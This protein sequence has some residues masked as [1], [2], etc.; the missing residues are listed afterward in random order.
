[1]NSFLLEKYLDHLQ[2]SSVLKTHK[3]VYLENGKAS[4]P[5]FLILSLS[6][7]KNIL[8][9]LPDEESTIAAF[10]ELY[11]LA[12]KQTSHFPP[13][14]LPNGEPY[15]SYEFN[16]QQRTT[17]LHQITSSSN[18]N[19]IVT[20]FSALTEPVIPKEHF[21]KHLFTIHQNENISYNFL[22][23]LLNDYQFIQSEFVYFPGQYAVRGHIIDIY[24]YTSE[25]PFRIELRNNTIVR[26]SE[27][28]PSTQMS[29]QNIEQA[30]IAPKT[31]TIYT[32]TSCLT[33]YFSN[34]DLFIL[35][36]PA[37]FKE[38]ETCQIPKQTILSEIFQKSHIEY[39]LTEHHT[40]PKI[41][42]QINPQPLFGK[43]YEDLAK[44]L[45][46][47]YSNGFTNVFVSTNRHSYQRLLQ[48]TEDILHKEKIETTKPLMEW[49]NADINEGFIDVKNKFTFYTEHQIFEKYHPIRKKDKNSETRASLTLK[50]LIQLNPGD[51]VVHIDHGIGRFAGL[52]TLEVNGKK[53]E[54]IKLL[55]KNNDTLF[56]NIH[57][58]YRLSKYS[59]KDGHEPKI[60][61][62]GSQRWQ[63][64][65][66]KIKTSVKTLAYDL[67]KLYAERK[68]SEGFAFSKDTYLQ[69]ELEAS[70]PFED[71]PD[72]A[73]VTREVKRDM[74]KPY[75][76]DRLICGD[77]GFG[78]TEIAIRAAF[79]AVCDG[80][81]VV[82]L[83]PTTIL[84]IQHF[85]TFSER[86]KNFPVTID[87]INRF[88]TIKEQKNILQKLQ[89]GKIDI[90][91]GTHKLLSKNVRFNDLGLLIID[92]EHK[93][94]VADKDKIKLLKKNIDT[95][96]LTAT[97]IPRTLQFSLIGA[98]DLSVIQTPPPNRYPVKT[99]LHNFSDDIIQAAIL[100]EIERG[101]QVFFIHNKVQDIF[102]MAQHIQQLVPKIRLSVAHGQMKNYELEDAVI[103][104]IRGDAQVLISTNIIESG[105]DISNANT[106]IIHNAQNFG[107]S[108]LHQ[109]RGRVGRSNRQAYCYLLV[110]SMNLLTNDAKKRLQAIL[111]FSDLGSGF[112][113]AMKDLDIRGA[114]NLLGPEQS[115][116]IN[117]IGIDAYMQILNEALSEIKHQEEEQPH[118]KATAF[119][120]FLM[121]DTVLDTDLPLF[122]PSEYVHDPTER[123]NLYRQLNSCTSYQQL[124]DFKN[125]LQDR[126]GELP[127]ETSELI[128]SVK[129]RWQASKLGFEK[130]I[131]K[132][133]K[134]IAVFINNSQHRFYK[135]DIFARLLQ[136]ISAQKNY[137][138]LKEQNNKLMLIFENIKDIHQ[139]K[140]IVQNILA[141][142]L[143]NTSTI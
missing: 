74:E 119:S 24:S 105:I 38:P 52:H 47:L 69:H 97:P 35:K 66:Q 22:I 129:L 33:Q 54:V 91:I 92:E 21:Q 4:F 46:T 44:H 108:D 127:K 95:L 73:K 131:L 128:E 135:T 15:K 115:G 16:L 51:Y 112:Q 139:A 60:D 37:L 6:P 137:G 40:L 71:T 104:F 116:F 78:K 7:H 103:K 87:F 138:T 132:N 133:G 81:Q 55:Y 76:M 18:G 107:L 68:A 110:P 72:Q 61:Q 140:S 114:G 31:E 130:L 2:L 8:W 125:M 27:F 32:E 102:E 118:H 75:P 12:P 86:L 109:L 3:N 34:Q 113:I 59:S 45:Y 143:E 80:K 100:K 141:M 29:F 85:H 25:Y 124:E 134:M 65:K 93:F 96:T 98:R 70:F 117:E 122:I 43:Q 126:F 123:L 42:V 41:Y 111:D 36:D 1:M 39:G 26:L 11:S 56:V 90:L 83:V 67:I 82:V 49:L 19:I 88:R 58:L 10:N 62:L 120:H 89:E 28:H 13:L 17:V 9:V 121:A 136:F 48:I 77:V 79:K 142:A 53:Q 63:N 57:N 64:L 84:A 14:Y 20:S 23:E 99:E 101:G 94:G 5:A 106:I 50:D 30:T